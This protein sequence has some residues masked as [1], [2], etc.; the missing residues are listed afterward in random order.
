MNL[1]LKILLD[2]QGGT[3]AITRKTAN[4]L[5]T[6]AGFNAEF[7]EIEAV[8]NGGIEAANIADDAVSAVKL[9]FDVVRAGYGL[10]QHTDGSLYVDVSDTNPGLE[11]TDGGIR[12]KVYGLLSRTANGIECMRSGDLLF[13]SSSTVPDGFT[14][15]SSTYNGKF[16]RI[17]SGTA[18]TAGGSDTHDHGAVTGSHALTVDEIPAH[19]HSYYRHSDT[20]YTEGNTYGYNQGKLSVN[21]GSTGGGGGHTHTVASADNVPAYVTTKCYQKS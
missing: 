17:S 14:D 19:T 18:L 4:T 7:A 3:L 16:I 5:I 6:A 9:N 15:V 12:A 1:L 8:V 20:P 13:T 10:V 11:I 2:E 21:T